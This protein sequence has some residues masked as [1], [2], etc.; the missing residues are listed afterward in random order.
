MVI[1]GFFARYFSAMKKSLFEFQSPKGY[2]NL[3]FCPR[4]VRDEGKKKEENLKITFV[5]QVLAHEFQP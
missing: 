5:E 3:E 4:K 1:L 2:R